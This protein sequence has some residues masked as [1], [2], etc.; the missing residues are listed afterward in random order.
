MVA[1]TM[2]AIWLG[3]IISEYG[4]QQQGCLNHLFGIVSDTRNLSGSWRIKRRADRAG[5]LSGG[6][7][8]LGI[9]D[10]LYPTGDKICETDDPRSTDRLSRH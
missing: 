2:V 10:R 6:L 1:G 3:Q 4:I 8:D 9:C 7:A 5:Y